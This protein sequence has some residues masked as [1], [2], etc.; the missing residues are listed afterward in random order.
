MPGF[1]LLSFLGLFLLVSADESISVRSGVKPECDHCTS[2]FEC[3]QGKCWGRPKKCTDGSTASLLR[4]GFKPA[5]E[6]CSKKFECATK[7]C[8]GGVC[9]PRRG[10]PDACGKK[11]ECEL[12][13]DGSECQQGKC[14][15]L[16]KKCTDGSLASRL[17]C[18]LGE[19]EA[20]TS[21]L[22]CATKKCWKKKCVFKTQAS[23]DR[24][25]PPLKPECALC[26]EDDECELGKCWGKPRKCTDGSLPSRERCFLGECESCTSKFEC[27]S[28]KCWN[29]KCVFNTA[30]SREKCFPT[31]V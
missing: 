20:C 24:C 10:S 27:A 5:C 31:T 13:S 19:C 7:K 15:G 18:F 16:P 22:Q 29:K 12:C 14:W 25:F 11:E 6:P 26:A 3:M 17:R 23:R 30:A 8:I 2:P 1:A 4:C 28:K 21:S 9:V